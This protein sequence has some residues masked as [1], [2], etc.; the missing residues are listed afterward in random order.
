MQSSPSY[1]R[2]FEGPALR[3]TLAGQRV[4]MLTATSSAIYPAINRWEDAGISLLDALEKYTNIC[5]SLAKESLLDGTPPTFLAA[6]IENTLGSIGSKF[7]RMQ[8]ILAQ[9]R[10]LA[11]APLHR[12]PEE[13]LSEI[14]AHVVFSPLDLS[15]GSDPD[16][17]RMCTISV[18][19]ALQN[20]LGICTLWRNLAMNQGAL[21]SIIPLFDKV[22]APQSYRSMLDHALRQNKG[23]G[24]SLVASWRYQSDISI[25]SN[26]ITQFQFVNIFDAS[27]RAIRAALAAFTDW[28]G[29]NPLSLN[30][31]SIH[32]QRSRGFH[33][34]VPVDDLLF[35]TASRQQSF[36]R[37]VK[38][39]T[40]LRI[41][42]TLLHW[43]TVRFSDRLTS[44]HL[45]DVLLGP[46]SELISLLSA[47]SSAAQ[48]R[49]LKLIQVRTYKD[50]TPLPNLVGHSRIRFPNLKS[51]FIEGLSFNTLQ[52]LLVSIQPQSYRLTL[53]LS[54][55]LKNMTPR[56]A[57]VT[58]AH[59]HELF[60]LLKHVPVHTFGLDLDLH[61]LS[62]HFKA[63]IDALPS[64]VTLRLKTTALTPA[65]CTALE[66]S[67]EIH[68][69]TSPT[70][71]NFHLFYSVIVDAE[72]FKRM[73]KS[74]SGSLQRLVLSGSHD[75]DNEHHERNREKALDD[76]LREI[77]PE[78]MRGDDTYEYPDH[79]LF[80]REER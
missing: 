59:L 52:I 73:V 43:Q 10:N 66:R 13:V 72:A 29:S 27:R 8:S 7:A 6:R 33:R 36:N 71:V 14:F 70:F 37:L 38:G 55:K 31:L 67:C 48:L 60:K 58:D 57:E 25:I 15:L 4:K 9:T 64:L 49:D 19:R 78:Y 41:K 16:S 77:V 45:Q 51:L 44:F 40:I 50:A 75:G 26:Y 30:Q 76:S 47:I 74:H 62:V 35:S 63:L 2:G 79:Q 21:W 32:R 68:G 69:F 80:I 11:V 65:N 53:M 56:T 23:V 17:V 12:F 34:N 39:L 61:R 5:C 1:S 46:D 24:L 3:E 18:H 42:N 54:P 20:L 22:K 28:S